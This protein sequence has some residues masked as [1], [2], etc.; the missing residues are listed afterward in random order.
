MLLLDGEGREQCDLS[1]KD[2]IMKPS[3]HLL[4]ND[5]SKSPGQHHVAKLQKMSETP[6]SGH[7]D[8]DKP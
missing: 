4:W 1:C 2:T 8:R 3:K 5:A 6:D 7:F